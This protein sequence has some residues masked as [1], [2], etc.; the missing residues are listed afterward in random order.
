MAASQILSK[1]SVLKIVLFGPGA[2][3]VY[4]NMQFYTKCAVL[5]PFMRCAVTKLTKNI[6]LKRSSYLLVFLVDAP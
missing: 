2:C 6:T 5:N 4:F 3:R 1:T